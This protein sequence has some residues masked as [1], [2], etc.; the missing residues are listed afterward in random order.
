M[1]G[2]SR[3][4][5]KNNG[6]IRPRYGHSGFIGVLPPHGSISAQ[7]ARQD[8]TNTGV[9]HKSRRIRKDTW[10]DMLQESTPTQAGSNTAG[11][12]Q[13]R[14]V[15]LLWNTMQTMKRGRQRPLYY[16]KTPPG[17][18]AYRMPVS[19]LSTIAKNGPTCWFAL[20]VHPIGLSY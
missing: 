13:K 10:D 18:V 19:R 9:A 14:Q 16:W 17:A 4:V 2:I 3:T 6:L 11:N 5:P 8:A 7:Q 12:T 20:L 1:P 15:S